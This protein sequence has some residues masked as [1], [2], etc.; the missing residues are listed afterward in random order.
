VA[1]QMNSSSILNFVGKDVEQMTWSDI[2]A[3]AEVGSLLQVSK[4]ITTFVDGSLH[5]TAIWPNNAMKWMK[6]MKIVLQE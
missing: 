2:T 3:E 1:K 6:W 4:L 5:Q